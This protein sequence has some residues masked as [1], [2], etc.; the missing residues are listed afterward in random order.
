MTGGVS[1]A[2]EV[3]L[4]QRLPRH[5]GIP[6]SHR[7][8]IFLARKETVYTTIHHNDAPSIGICSSGCPFS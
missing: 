2:I 3:P 4:T 1:A 8:S 5:C 6:I 7:A